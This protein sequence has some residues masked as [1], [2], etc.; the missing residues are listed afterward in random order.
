MVLD[1][2][3]AQVRLSLNQRFRGVD[4]GALTKEAFDTTRLSGRGDANVVLAGTGNTYASILRSLGGKIDFNV[5]EG[6]LNGVDLSYELRRAQALLSRQPMPVQAGPVRTRFNTFSGSANLEAGVLR[7]DDLSIETDYLKAH[8]KGTLD[9][10]TRAIDYRLIASVYDAPPTG[11]RGAQGDAKIADIP[12]M[13]TGNLG[14][15]KIRPDLEALAA[16]K[17]RQ[18]VSKRLQGKGDTLKQLGDR[19]KSLLGH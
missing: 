4:V 18:E 3:P 1:A 16:A 8:G 9:L 15:L 14:N 5:N 7:N 19:L 12:L 13:L 6:A 10:G 11:A 2:A 17:V